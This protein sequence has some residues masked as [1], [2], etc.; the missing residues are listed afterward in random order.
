[1]ET[2]KMGGNIRAAPILLEIVVPVTLTAPASPSARMARATDARA[3]LALF[4][5]LPGA[6][7]D[8]LDLLCGSSAGR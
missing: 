6:E 8:A 5:G 7:Q 4:V 3:S 1:M 2:G